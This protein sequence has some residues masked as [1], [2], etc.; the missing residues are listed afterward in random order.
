MFIHCWREDLTKAES[1]VLGTEESCKLVEDVG[2]I[3][4]EEGSARARGMGGEEG[5]SCANRTMI[6]GRIMNFDLSTTMTTTAPLY[7]L[8][9]ILGMQ[10]TRRRE[11]N[12]SIARTIAA[13][14]KGQPVDADRRRL[15]WRLTILYRPQ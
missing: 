14:C 3:G 8:G 5:L 13:G 9:F 10:G 7:V 1:R 15:P 11:R 2:A 6:W 12:G 4:L